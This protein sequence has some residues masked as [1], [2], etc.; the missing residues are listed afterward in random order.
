MSAERVTFR[1]FNTSC[2]IALPPPEMPAPRQDGERNEVVTNTVT[3]LRRGNPSESGVF[4]RP[5][6][7]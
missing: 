7:A 4:R 6:A 2:V 5:D 3:P 1:I